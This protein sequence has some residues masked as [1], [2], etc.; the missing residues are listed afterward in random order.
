MIE[1]LSALGS[2]TPSLDVR[3]PQS[4]AAPTGG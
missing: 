3:G 4:T 2:A 1:G